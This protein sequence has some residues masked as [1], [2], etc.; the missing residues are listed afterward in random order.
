MLFIPMLL[1][2]PTLASN[3]SAT[4][5]ITEQISVALKFKSEKTAKSKFEFLFFLISFVSHL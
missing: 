1:K 3:L 4:G 2:A 5:L